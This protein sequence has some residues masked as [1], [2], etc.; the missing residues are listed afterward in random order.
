M[1]RSMKSVSFLG[2]V[3]L[4]AL[5][6]QASPAAACT[7]QCQQ[8]PGKPLFCRQCVDTGSFT[9]VTCANSGPC[10]CYYVPNSCRGAAVAASSSDSVKDAIFA[11]PEARTET[12]STPAFLTSDPLA[13]N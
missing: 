5:A 13:A 1:T 3:L 6:L 9:N 2:A 7:Y 4:V 8:V 11:A 12:A 10:G